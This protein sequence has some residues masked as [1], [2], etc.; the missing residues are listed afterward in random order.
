V[1]GKGKELLTESHQGGETYNKW[2]SYGQ[3][4]TANMLM[5]L[6]LAEKLGPKGLRA[7]SL[8]PGGILTNLGDH[9]DFAAEMADLGM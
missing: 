2:R 6:S 9:L 8:H 5:A 7:F 3:S 1:T 4:K